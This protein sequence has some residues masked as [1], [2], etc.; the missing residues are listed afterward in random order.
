MTKFVVYV[1]KCLLITGISAIALFALMVVLIWPQ[2][3]SQVR[4]WQQD[5]ERYES[6]SVVW[7][8]VDTFDQEELLQ[9]VHREIM[10]TNMIGVGGLGDEGNE[11]KVAAT[12]IMFLINR[13]PHTGKDLSQE[14]LEQAIK[15]VAEAQR[16]MYEAFERFQN[17][18]L[19]A[20]SQTI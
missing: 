14:S 19:Y 20:M 2:H 9:L 15:Q 5:M 17:N 13:H 1:F 11:L 10:A 18:W 8:E 4:E 3:I 6:L 12:N 7:S 16:Q